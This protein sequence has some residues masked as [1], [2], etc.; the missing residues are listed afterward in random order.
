[1]A[2]GRYVGRGSLLGYGPQVQVTAVTST[3]TKLPN[4]G[5]ASFGSTAAK[6]W[7]I[8]MPPEIG[9][10]VTLYCNAATLT[11]VQTVDSTGGAVFQG[12]Q[13]AVSSLRFTKAYTSL[14]LIG[15]TTALYQVRS[16]TDKVTRTVT[17]STSTGTIANTGVQN[18]GPGSSGVPNWA[19][20]KPN[21]AGEEVFLS[22][23]LATSSKTATVTCVAGSW[24]QSTNSTAATLR[25]ATFAD[26]GD[27][28]HLIAKTTAV[29]TVFGNVGTVALAS[30]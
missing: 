1:M 2:K 22:C 8:T 20:A 18:F 17:V 21:R 6:T 4:W 30:T 28:L 27:S 11:A 16:A 7:N 5:I 10:T 24:F 3:A 14:D 29:W 19:L 13:G 9:Q 15:L 26:A 12:A 25:K 23:T